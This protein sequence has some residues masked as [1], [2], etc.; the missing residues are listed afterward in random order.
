VLKIQSP[1]YK[2]LIN[3]NAIIINAK[4]KIHSEMKLL[5][6]DLADKESIEIKIK[7][8]TVTVN[9]IKNRYP[10]ITLLYLINKNNKNVAVPNV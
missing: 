5:I 9:G 2:N 4:R 3:N 10:F 6:F 1:N 8:T 7:T